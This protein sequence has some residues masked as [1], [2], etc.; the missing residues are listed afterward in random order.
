MVQVQPRNASER[1]YRPVLSFQKRVQRRKSSEGHS[2]WVSLGENQE[3]RM[4]YVISSSLL[5]CSCGNCTDVILFVAM[6]V[7]CRLKNC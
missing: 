6:P 7:C 3:V 2:R 1:G 5:F 4:V